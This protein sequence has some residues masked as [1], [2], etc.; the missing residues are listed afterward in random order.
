MKDDKDKINI[1][2]ALFEDRVQ[3]LIKESCRPEM[4]EHALVYRA[5]IA[6]N[7][8]WIGVLD[9]IE[10]TIARPRRELSPGFNRLEQ[11]LKAANPT[12]KPLRV[13]PVS[14]E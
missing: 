9:E 10:A 8:F 1:T 11:A 3:E 13:S 14:K 7:E 5:Q 2:R 4:A 12:R 6:E